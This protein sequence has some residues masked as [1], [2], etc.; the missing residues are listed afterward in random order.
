MNLRILL[1]IREGH[2][3]SVTLEE[4]RA[5]R[6]QLEQLPSDGPSSRF[7]SGMEVE[8][9]PNHALQRTRRAARGFIP[10]LLCAGSLSLGR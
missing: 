5:L 10:H 1:T 2:T 6:Q 7:R 9:W 8:M 3:V 4:A